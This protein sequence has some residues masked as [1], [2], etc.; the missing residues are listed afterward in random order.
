M[1]ERIH[2]L[3]GELMRDTDRGTRLVIRLPLHAEG[4]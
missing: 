3:G 2:A 4:R 1:R